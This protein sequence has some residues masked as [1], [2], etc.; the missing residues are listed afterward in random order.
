MAYSNGRLPQSVLA[1]IT[2]AVG[3][4]QVYLRK[5][6][7]KAFNAMNHESETKHGI[8][9]RAT[10]SKSAYRTIA[11]QEW[12]WDHCEHPHDTNWVAE[13]GTSNHGWG[14]AIDLATPAMRRIVDQI[15]EKYGF[16]KHWSD[17]PGEWWHIKWREGNYPAVNNPPYG[18]KPLKRGQTSSRVIELKK[19]L[20]NHGLRDFGSRW[21]PF[22]NKTAQ[23]AVKRFQRRHNLSPDGVVGPKTWALLKGK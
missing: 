8:T 16:A 15:G 13:P 1:P 11:Q 22:F 17:A 21:N 7:A 6:A 5:D 19:M 20:Y 18:F 14:L 2:K 4:A 23:D 9:L 12:L 3:G 10:G